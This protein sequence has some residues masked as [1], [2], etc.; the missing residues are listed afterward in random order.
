MELLDF[1][2][3]AHDGLL[4]ARVPDGYY[5]ILD[6]GRDGF[7]VSGYVNSACFDVGGYTDI[8]QALDAANKHYDS[9]KNGRN[10]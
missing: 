10:G 8:Y 2:I 6:Y 9:V 1:R 7:T 4:E 3:A 5:A